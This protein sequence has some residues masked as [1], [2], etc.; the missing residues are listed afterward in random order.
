MVSLR[1]V[2]ARLAVAGVV[3]VAAIEW[4]LIVLQPGDGPFAVLQ[5]LAPH[6][7]LVGLAFV[8]VAV[9]A[10]RDRGTLIPALVLLSAVG[11]R[12]GGEWLSLPSAVAAGDN[13]VDVVTWNLEAGSR[14]GAETAATLAAHPAD[15]VALQELQPDVAAA[16]AAHPA[17][18]SLYPYRDLEPDETVLGLGLLS[19][20]P[21]RGVTTSHWPAI[22]QASVV[23]NDQ[24]IA[25][26]NGHPMH[27]AFEFLANT[28]LPIGID[29]TARDGDLETIDQML[30]R[31]EAAGVPAILLGDLNTASSEPAFH[32][33][34]A[35]RRDVHAE[36]GQGPG[37]TW[38]PIRLEFLGMGLVRI[39]QVIVSSDI[40]PVAISETCPPVGDH[41]LVGA[42]VRLP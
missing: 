6:L 21:L 5:V 9:A 13:T 30:D 32:R 11:L 18:A 38:R 23:V 40:A 37:W 16:I 27:G 2:V 24:T 42:T 12:F 10:R 4:L 33:L 41:C 1:T 8:P 31:Q 15:V 25:L 39:D 20:F 35:G 19:R 22:Q 28:R 7:A 14:P 3:A 26:I 17:L 29:N 34:I 36:V